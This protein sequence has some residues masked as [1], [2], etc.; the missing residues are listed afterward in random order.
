MSVGQTFQLLIIGGL[1][2]CYVVTHCDTAPVLQTPVKDP[3]R[4]AW[5]EVKKV[6]HY[7]LSVNA[8]QQP[9]TVKEDQAP[10]GEK[11]P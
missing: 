3:A 8:L 1:I 4:L 6:S 7:Y 10:Y 5:N 2:L 11:R 9:M